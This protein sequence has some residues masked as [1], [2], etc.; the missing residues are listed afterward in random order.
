MKCN[1]KHNYLKNRHNYNF[2]SNCGKILR[3]R[4]IF[5]KIFYFFFLL[6]IPI[7]FAKTESFPNTITIGTTYMVNNESNITSAAFNI[8]TE[9]DTHTYN[10][11]SNSTSAFIFTLNRNVSD[12]INIVDLTNSLHNFTGNVNSLLSTCNEVT[13]QYGD[14]N[15][16]FKL[17]TTCNTENELCKKDKSD[18]LNKIAELGSAKTNFDTCTQNLNQLN[19]QISQYSTQLSNIQ[20]NLTSMANDKNKA[21]NQRI[22]FGIGGLLIMGGIMLYRETKKNPTLQRHKTLGL[23]GGPQR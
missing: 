13:K 21:E 14:T 5:L 15:T 10:C 18:Q 9:Q 19:S 16:Y 2:C 7:V 17:Y 3:L 12:N 22:I 8:T 1:K 23:T 11:L 6:L 4:G 20:G